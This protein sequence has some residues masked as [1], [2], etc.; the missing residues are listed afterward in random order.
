MDAERI[1]TGSIILLIIIIPIGI[2][3]GKAFFKKRKIVRSLKILA[4]KNNEVVSQYDHWNNSA[5]GLT[6]TGKRV[7]LVS[8]G[9]EDIKSQMVDLTMYTK[10]ILVNDNSKAEYME[11]NFKVTDSIALELTGPNNLKEQ[12]EF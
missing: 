4:Q 1:V 11:G 10:C 5:I 8:N 7:F 6:Q 9:E 12:I 3:K 2:M